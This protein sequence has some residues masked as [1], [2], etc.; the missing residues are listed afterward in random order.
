MMDVARSYCSWRVD[1]S[2]PDDG[3]QEPSFVAL[4]VS[5]VDHGLETVV[6]CL[7]GGWEFVYCRLI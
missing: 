6:I 3:S 2:R 5:N 7:A 1:V 4:R